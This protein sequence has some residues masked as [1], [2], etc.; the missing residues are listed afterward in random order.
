MQTADKLMFID[1]VASRLG[2]SIAQVRWMVTSENDFPKPA[3]ISGRLCWRESQIEKFI[4]DAFAK[5]A[6]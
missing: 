3:K 6:S 2:R 5:A 4:D 1:E